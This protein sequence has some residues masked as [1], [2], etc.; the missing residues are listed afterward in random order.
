MDEKIHL[1][2]VYYNYCNY[3]SR[4]TN[5]EDFLNRYSSNN[6]FVFYVVELSYNDKFYLTN[7]DNINHLQVKSNVPLWHKEN[8]IN[9]A[10]Y[11]MIP[12]DAKY[13]GWIDPNIIFH[14]NDYNEQIIR[15]CNK[16]DI[17]Q[18]F[19]TMINTFT[20][21]KTNS[22]GLNR[23]SNT[24]YGHHGIGFVMRR[25]IANKIF[26]LYDKCIVGGCDS[27]IIYGI[28]NRNFI[29]M[30][31]RVNKKLI[32]NMNIYIEKIKVYK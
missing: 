11:K 18:Y 26:P 2:V 21:V 4:R 29:K 19:S 25:D 6:K 32:D 9:L 23:L 5:T 1:I 24:K 7:K 20:K 10:F 30:I 16:Y 22:Y 28:D 17:V 31:C 8:L 27:A 15:A 12:Q 13:I 3:N 14:D